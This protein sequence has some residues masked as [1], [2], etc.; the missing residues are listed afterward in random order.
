L[1]RFAT[2]LLV[3]IAAV[4]ILGG[5]WAVLQTVAW[6]KML[7]DNARTESLAE[8]LVKTFDG[9]K[10]CSLCLAVKEGRASDEKQDVAKLL[11]KIEA[12][13]APQIQLPA[14]AEAVRRFFIVGLV[15][16]EVSFAPPT[17]PPRST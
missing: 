5:H 6:T 15:D 1:L 17:P 14:R 7:V 4:Q 8:A 10:P 2:K 16:R 9:S 13:L 12:I 11:V 3:L